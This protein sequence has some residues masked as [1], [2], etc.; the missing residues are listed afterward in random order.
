MFQLSGWREGAGSRQT[1]CGIT[2]RSALSLPLPSSSFFPSLSL[3]LTPSLSL[4]LS[5]SH[6]L[7]FFL[8]F[9]FLFHFSTSQISHSCHSTF[10]CSYFEE[11]IPFPSMRQNSI[12][13]IL[14]WCSGR[15]GFS[16][17]VAHFLSEP[18]FSLAFLFLHFVCYSW[19]LH[20]VLLKTMGQRLQTNSETP[21]VCPGVWMHGLDAAGNEMKWSNL[22]PSRYV[23]RSNPTRS[24]E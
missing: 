11:F 1:Q 22:F 19:S 3:Y 7:A 20:G 15:V 14:C 23:I 12:Y 2:Q 13:L 5:L 21:E 9:S 4:S 18:F 8:S 10:G 6:S 24:H 17:G 16:G